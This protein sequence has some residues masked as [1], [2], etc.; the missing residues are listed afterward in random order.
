MAPERDA[1][2]EPATV[3]AELPLPFAPVELTS[4]APAA[5]ARHEPLHAAPGPW[6]PI[7]PRPGAGAGCARRS[8]S[9]C[10][11]WP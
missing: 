9:A 2:P 1:A 10:S 3:R 11:R 8:A 5:L 4:S 6:K 7:G